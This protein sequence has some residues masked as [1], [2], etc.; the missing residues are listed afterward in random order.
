MK[1]VLV[2]IAM[3]IG[4]GNG[5]MIAATPAFSINKTSSNTVVADGYSKIEIKDIP[6]SV[7]QAVEKENPGCYFFEA[8][9][10]TL[11]GQ[12]VYKIELID[13]AGE[14]FVV[15]VNERGENIK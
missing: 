14:S 11:G 8:Y 3:V 2:A 12:T 10:G 15:V 5:I 4:L 1:K 13:N 6:E 9:I 7:M